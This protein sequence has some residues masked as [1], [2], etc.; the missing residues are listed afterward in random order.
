MQLKL[1][2]IGRIESR[3]WGI[4]VNCLVEEEIFTQQTLPEKLECPREGH[5][6]SVGNTSQMED[7]KRIAIIQNRL[8]TLGEEAEPGTKGFPSAVKGPLQLEK[9]FN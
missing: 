2:I 8:R 5:L 6:L 9:I 3:I 1:K 7:L 4:R